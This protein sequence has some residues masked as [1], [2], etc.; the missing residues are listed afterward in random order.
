M[1]SQLQQVEAQ[2]HL[3]LESLHFDESEAKKIGLCK[4]YSVFTQ[5][6]CIQNTMNAKPELNPFA[7]CSRDF[8]LGFLIV[9]AHT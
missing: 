7:Q 5:I 1:V 8:L 9:N 3:S 2:L 6:H 4:L